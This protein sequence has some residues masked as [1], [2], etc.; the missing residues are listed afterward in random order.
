MVG[1]RG[2]L[3]LGH[4]SLLWYVYMCALCVPVQGSGLEKGPRTSADP[5]C[6]APT[7]G[8][9]TGARWICQAEQQ[10]LEHL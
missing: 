10:G 6:P 5:L 1:H 8:E 3:I 2:F 7:L 9:R 4:L